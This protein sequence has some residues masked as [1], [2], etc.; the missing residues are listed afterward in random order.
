MLGGRVTRCAR[1]CLNGVH[2]G[3][4]DDAAALSMAKHERSA[5][6]ARPL[7]KCTAGRLP[8][9]LTYLLLSF[10]V[11]PGFSNNGILL[12]HL[13]QLVL[14][15]EPHTHRIDFDDFSPIVRGGLPTDRG[16]GRVRKGRYIATASFRLTT[17][18]IAD[19]VCQ[20]SLQRSRLARDLE[21]NAVLLA[22]LLPLW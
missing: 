2:A 4:I 6:V 7:G 11:K 3:S 5:H 21:H 18:A 17:R 1:A 16:R 9:S 15:A 8:I 12:E 20:Q 14:H 19:Q 13:R 22:R 10:W